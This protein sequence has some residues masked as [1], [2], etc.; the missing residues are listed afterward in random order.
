L[1]S[2]SLTFDH[3]ITYLLFSFQ[4]QDSPDS[5]FSFAIEIGIFSSNWDLIGRNQSKAGRSAGPASSG[6]SSML[7]IL[8]ANRKI[9]KR[10]DTDVAFTREYSR[11]SIF[12]R[13]REC[14]N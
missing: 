11:V 12:H 10:T 4:E 1:F 7:G 9:R 6:Y 3:Q 14:T 2:I 13:E 5:L 8:N